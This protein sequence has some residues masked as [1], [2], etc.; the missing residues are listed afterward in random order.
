MKTR[1]VARV[2][3]Y[4]KKKILLCK[5]NNEDFWYPPGGGWEDGESL[6][7]CCKREVMEEVGVKINTQDIMYVHEFY[8]RSEG[9]R[10][11]EIF[12]LAYPESDSKNSI[13]KNGEK[14][15]RWFSFEDMG[16]IN[17]NPIFMRG[18][19]WIDLEKFDKN[20]KIYWKMKE[21]V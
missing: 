4:D 3:I 18:Q 6:L 15:N 12:F 19:L 10:N 17:V 13:N 1:I 14:E 7:D 8:L 16:T 5:N 21:S 2:I 20:K 11:L 9:K